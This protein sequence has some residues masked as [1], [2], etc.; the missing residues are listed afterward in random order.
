M[1]LS[2]LLKTYEGG[3][4][5]IEKRTQSI[6]NEIDHRIEEE[7]IKALKLQNHVEVISIRK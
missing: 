7:T 1:N 5:Q 3:K 2:E 4:K 6:R